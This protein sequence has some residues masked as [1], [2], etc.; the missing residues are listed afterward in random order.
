MAY[1]L[2]GPAVPVFLPWQLAEWVN[3]GA[4]PALMEVDPALGGAASSTTSVSASCVDSSL[5]PLRVVPTASG[6]IPM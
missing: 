6:V 3:E 1:N 2:G 5:S 4:P